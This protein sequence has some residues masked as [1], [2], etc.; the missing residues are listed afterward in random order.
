MELDSEH[1]L[2]D[3]ELETASAMPAPRVASP[4]PSPS[5]DPLALSPLSSAPPRLS[6]ARLPTSSPLSP[7]AALSP[8]PSPVQ[9]PA[10][11]REPEPAGRTFRKRTT[12][13]LQPYTL[14]QTKYTRTLLQNGWQGA[15]VAGLPRGGDLSADELRRRKQLAERAPKDDLGGWLEFSQGQ[16]VGTSKGKG[17]ERAR[18]VSNDDDDE[19]E[20]DGETLLEREARRKERMAR[21][22]ER[23]LG[24]RKRATRDQSDSDS[25]GQSPACPASGAQSECLCRFWRA[26]LNE[27]QSRT[28]TRRTR[29][30]R[31]SVPPSCRAS[32]RGSDGPTTSE[33]AAAAGRPSRDNAPRQ[34]RTVSN[35]LSF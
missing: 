11:E 16:A 22:V 27:D 14:E 3:M 5:P 33:T 26:Q 24:S 12:A 29:S 18:E 32:P 1:S 28:A 35:A 34:T 10:P 8:S 20:V 4:S 15:V 9:E 6:P 23:A 7:P 30:A 21:D 13:Q 19:V 25:R 31:E 17:K 2:S